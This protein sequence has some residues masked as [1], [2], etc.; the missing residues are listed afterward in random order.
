MKERN[1][2]P[3]SSFFGGKKKKFKD[4]E[5]GESKKHEKSESKFKEK[6]ESGPSMSFKKKFGMM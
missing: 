3:L 4:S 6:L 2:M 5:K 1:P